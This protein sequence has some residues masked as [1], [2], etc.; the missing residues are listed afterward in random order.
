MTLYK[1]SILQALQSA[2]IPYKTTAT[3]PIVF[4]WCPFHPDEK[5]PSMAIYTNDAHFFCFGCSKGGKWETLAK[6]F[7]LATVANPDWYAENSVGKLVKYLEGLVEK[8]PKLPPN[9]KKWFLGEWRSCSKILLEKLNTRWWWD[10]KDRTA[11]ILWP[12]WNGLGDLTG[13]AARRLDNNDVIRKYRN[14]TYMRV[15]DILWPFPVNNRTKEKTV[16]LVEGPYDAIRLLNLGLPALALLGTRWSTSRD[17]LIDILGVNRVILA[18]DGD[19]AGRE[20][21]NKIG[22][23][24]TKT[25][26]KKNVFIWSWNNG[27]DPGSAKTKEIKELFKETRRRRIKP[28]HPWIDSI[29]TIQPDWFIDFGI[30]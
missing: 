25:L 27:T 1:N 9:T 19:S 8:E 10:D 17:V 7:N 16:I 13:W 12:I 23:Q 5:S 29:P 11:R 22:Y 30:N 26:G 15:L 18:L 21:A 24:L 6:S 4:I 28:Y 20:G 2:K 14:A 3:S